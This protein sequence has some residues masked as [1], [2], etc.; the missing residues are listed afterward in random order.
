MRPGHATDTVA[1]VVTW[2]HAFIDVGAEA[3]EATGAFWSAVTGWPVGEPWPGHPEFRSFE[4]AVGAA[5]LHV[6]RI[7][8]PPRVHLDLM[9]R[10][11]DADRDAH[12]A[13]GATA[14]ERYPWWQVMTSPGG[15]PYCLVVDRHERRR[16]PATRWPQGH[17][18][19][20]AQVCL[21]IPARCFD[22]EVSFWRSAC[23]WPPGHADLPEY[24]RLT[25]SQDSPMFFLLQRLGPGETGPVRA[26]LDIGTDDFGA[27]VDRVRALGAKSQTSS[28]SWV[29]FTD[30][31]G[32]PFCVTH[33]P[34]E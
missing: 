25:P 30:P 27:E 3:V 15:L 18:S 1:G 4:P 32:L 13:L 33:R 14:V 20:V 21:D 8:G 10:D 28:H 19:R 23:G 34:P 16:P 31:A 29:V 6:Q 11:V 17:R 26:H 5:Y 7:S 2:M 22:D 12:V 9:S 24:R